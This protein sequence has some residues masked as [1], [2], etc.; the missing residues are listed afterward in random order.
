[1]DAGA[2]CFLHKPVDLRGR[3][4]VDCLYAALY[5]RG[6]LIRSGSPHN[7]RSNLRLART[8]FQA[9][10]AQPIALPRCGTV[11]LGTRHQHSSGSYLSLEL[12]PEAYGYLKIGPINSEG[13]VNGPM[14]GR[15][16][17]PQSHS[18]RIW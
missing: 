4:L 5:R 2:I 11:H 7:C 3:R 15:H 8:G 9:T 10:T 16:P 13:R 17:T 14:T 18:G 1:L 6:G 12:R